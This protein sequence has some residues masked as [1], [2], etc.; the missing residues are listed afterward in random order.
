M[1]IARKLV[2]LSYAFAP[3]IGGIETVSLLVARGFAR[4]GDAVTVVTRTPSSG[5]EPAAPFRVVRRPGIPTL[6]GAIA[7]ADRVLVSNLSLHLGWPLWC[8][9]WRKPFVLVH[10]TTLARTDGRRRW[11]DRLKLALLYRPHHM[12]VSRFLAERIGR[13]AGLIRNP[14][15]S[16]VFHAR[17]EIGRD[18][19]LLF[20]GR[21]AYAKGV[22]L[23]LQAL[24]EVV[25]RR[26]WTRLAIIGTGGEEPRLR[27]L[28]ATLEL[29]D[30][31]DFVGAREGEALAQWMNR[32]RILVV[33]SRSHPPE[34]C[35]VVPVEAMACGC[36]PVASRMGGLPEAVG[37]A[38][39]LFEEG[40]TAELARVL[41]DLLASP[42]RLAECRA[43]AGA[44][45]RGFEPESVL[46]AYEA[47]FAGCGAG[48]ERAR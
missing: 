26:P 37:A 14:Y 19:D 43:R 10:H 47:A 4:R 46:D 32:S 25:A 20:V 48:R 22:D 41:L 38:G 44:Q 35:P 12:A 9:F 40:N 5:P 2:I 34:I 13:G 23:L 18:R 39:V 33:P 8:L 15:N 6:L 3:Q 30:A 1:P 7:Q 31:V 24:R 16:A 11:R 45:L 28:T 17:P 42:E 27:A 29:D 36:V 21:L